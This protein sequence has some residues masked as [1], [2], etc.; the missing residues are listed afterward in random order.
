MEYDVEIIP[1]KLV[2]GKGLEILLADSYCEALGLH[3]VANQPT[4]D[5]L[6]MNQNKE[7]IMDK[8]SD[9]SWYDDIVYFMLHLQ[10]PSHLNKK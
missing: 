6:Q 9:S 2:K 3:L 10:F 4:Q 8:Y 7:H 5:E 1:T